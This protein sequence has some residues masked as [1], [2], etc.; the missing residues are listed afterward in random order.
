[1]IYGIGTD[2]V[3]VDRIEKALKRFGMS[4][5]RRIL[6][7]TELELMF[8]SGMQVGQGE[9]YSRKAV[10]WLASRFAAKEATT[11]ALGTGFRD[12]IMLTNIATLNNSLGK[13]ELHFFGQSAKFIEEKAIVHSHI[14]ISH[15][16]KNAIAFVILEV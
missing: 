9:E 12:G 10:Q 8:R 14:S 1:M 6:H 7:Q 5:C 4:F 2:I 15:E 3:E 16:K 13:P 11:K